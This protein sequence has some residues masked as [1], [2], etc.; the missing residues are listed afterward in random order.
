MNSLNIICNDDIIVIYNYIFLYK[1]LLK[2]LVTY[3]LGFRKN[4]NLK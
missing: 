1:H 4:K 2:K 3:I